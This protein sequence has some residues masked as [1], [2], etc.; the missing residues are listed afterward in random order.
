MHDER[1]YREHR[2]QHEPSP[3]RLAIVAASPPPTGDLFSADRWPGVV[4]VRAIVRSLACTPGSKVARRK[5]MHEAGWL[6]VDAHWPAVEKLDEVAAD[7]IILDGYDQLRAAV[8][9]L[10]PE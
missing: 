6:V 3:V 8:E 5:A 1:Y 9:K 7:K 2:K 10:R 4:L